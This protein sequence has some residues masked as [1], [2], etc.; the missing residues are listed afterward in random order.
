MVSCHCFSKVNAWIS[1]K[2]SS[3]RTWR[4]A[5]AGR[6]VHLDAPWVKYDILWMVAKF[7]TKTMVE[8]S[9]KSWEI[10]KVGIQTRLGDKKRIQV[11]G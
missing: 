7:C 4:G 1:P 5:A 11:S 9:Y 3:T 8:N 6:E 10:P 2:R